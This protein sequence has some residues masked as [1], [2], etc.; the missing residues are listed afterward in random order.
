MARSKT[1]FTLSFTRIFIKCIFVTYVGQP[2]C[3]ICWPSTLLHMLAIHCYICWPSTLLHM[4]AIHCYICW[5]STLLHM[6]TIHTLL[7]NLKCIFSSENL[8][9]SCYQYTHTFMF[10]LTLTVPSLNL[11][12]SL[13]IAKP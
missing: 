7:L 2:H 1:N 4:L 10:L 8:F 11:K 5:P 9:H 3:Y 6:L 12:I 13:N